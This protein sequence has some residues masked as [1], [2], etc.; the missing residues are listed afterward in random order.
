MGEGSG[1][2]PRVGPAPAVA[3]VAVPAASGNVDIWEFCKAGIQEHVKEN[4][5]QNEHQ[6]CQICC[7]GLDQY[8]KHP[9]DI[10]GA[11]VVIFPV[12]QTYVFLLF[13]VELL[14]FPKETYTLGKLRRKEPVKNVMYFHCFCYADAIASGNVHI[15]EV[16]ALALPFCASKHV[17]PGHMFK[18]LVFSPHMGSPR[19][20]GALLPV[21]T[22]R[23][24]RTECK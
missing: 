6:S 16:E 7:L 21:H 24:D 19:H 20:G 15:A 9:R 3:P 22:Y 13:F 11:V 10:F 4:N 18:P 14:L 2:G 23:T 5:S 8:D 12:G 1:W 17:S